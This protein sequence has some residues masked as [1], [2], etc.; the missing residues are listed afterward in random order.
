VRGTNLAAAVACAAL[1]APVLAGCGEQKLD[2]GKAESAIRAGIARQTGLEIESVRCPNEVE[3][4]R[5]GHFRC[6]AIAAN[7]D[8]A[9]VRVTQRDDQGTV[10][11]KL[12]G[13][14]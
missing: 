6:M 4:K 5:D 3:A 11:W 2:T 12:V 8:R 1:A 13:S 14:R 10:T 7:G 9:S